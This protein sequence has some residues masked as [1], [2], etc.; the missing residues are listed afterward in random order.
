MLNQNNHNESP[1]AGETVQRDENGRFVRGNTLG[2]RF[3]P[4]KSGNPGGSRKAGAY[5]RD[6]L[7]RL[8]EWPLV[9]LQRLVA[10]P[11]NVPIAKLIAAQRLLDAAKSGSEGRANTELVIEHTDGKAVQRIETTP[12]DNRSIQERMEALRKQLDPYFS[13]DN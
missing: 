3:E 1:S 2:N 13:S 4:G 8:A 5:I 11:D 9:E 10:D 7:N 6:W 12:V